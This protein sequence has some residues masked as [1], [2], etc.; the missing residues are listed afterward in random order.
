[1]KRVIRILYFEGPDKWIDVTLKNSW[2]QPNETIS[3]AS[4]HIAKELGRIVIKDD[5]F[6]EGKE[7]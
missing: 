4:G 2:L 7:D 3:I 5:A 1:M 6:L